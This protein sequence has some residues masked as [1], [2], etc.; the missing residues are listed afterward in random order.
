[1]TKMVNL[2]EEVARNRKSSDEGYGSHLFLK[3]EELR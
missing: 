3:R 2:M 1:M